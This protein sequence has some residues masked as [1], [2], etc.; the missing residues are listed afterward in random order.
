MPTET[1][2]QFSEAEVSVEFASKREEELIAAAVA[3]RDAHDWLHTS[4]G[5]YVIGA[6]VQDQQD[7]E[8][9]L[10]SV[11]PWNRRRILRLQQKHQAV[12]LAVGWLTEMVK[13]GQHAEQQLELEQTTE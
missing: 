9:R 11:S 3:G 1:E 7:I 2:R 5:R 4:V 13:N 8:R 10:A 6:A 12:E